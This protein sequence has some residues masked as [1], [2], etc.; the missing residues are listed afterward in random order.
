MVYLSCSFGLHKLEIDMQ[1]RN[2]FHA[3]YA[4]P[5]FIWME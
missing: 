3:M 1:I 4:A 5:K 2:I